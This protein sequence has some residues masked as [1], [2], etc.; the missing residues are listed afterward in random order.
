MG[1]LAEHDLTLV[2]TKLIPEKPDSKSL[3]PNSKNPSIIF[4]SD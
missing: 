3:P 1:L 4:V 2:L